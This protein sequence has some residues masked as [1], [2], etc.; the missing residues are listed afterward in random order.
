MGLAK[1]R[2][3]VVIELKAT[4]VRVRQYP[5]SQEARRGVTPHI[6][7]ED[8]TLQKEDKDGWYRDQNN[9]LILPATLGHHLC[10]HLH[11]ATLT[12]LQMACLRFPRQNATVQ[13]II[14]ACNACQLM[15]A[16]KKH[17]TGMRY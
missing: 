6:I 8:T 5:M 7:N 10:E 2:H 9:N 11:T 4:P 3:P 1:Q 16:E 14:Q 15:R 13:D 12:L 17:H